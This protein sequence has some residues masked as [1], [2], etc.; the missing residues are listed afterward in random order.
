MRSVSRNFQSSLVFNG[1]SNRVKITNANLSTILPPNFLT[2]CAWVKTTGPDTT[3]NMMVFARDGGDAG[4]VWQLGINSSGVTFFKVFK[5]EAT[6]ATATGSRVITDGEWHFIMGTWDGTNIT[7]FVDGATDGSPTALSGTAINQTNNRDPY[8]GFWP[9]NSATEWYKGYMTGAALFNTPFTLAMHQNKYH[10]DVKYSQYLV[11]EHDSLRDVVDGSTSYKVHD[12]TNTVDADPFSADIK[13]L[14]VPDLDS[15]NQFV[16]NEVLVSAN[17]KGASIF[18]TASY[19]DSYL[20]TFNGNQYIVFIDTSLNVMVGKRATG[21]ASFTIVDTGFNITEDD[22]HNVAAIGIDPGGTIHLAWDHHGTTLEYARSNAPEDITAF[23][24]RAMVGTLEASVSY[25]RFFVANNILFFA[26]RDGGSIDGDE[27]LNK[28]T[29]ATTTWS[30]VQGPLVDGQTSNYGTYP[31]SYA[32]D[33]TGRI[34]HAFCWRVDDDPAILYEDFTYMYSDDN[35]ATWYNSAGVQYTLPV[36]PAQAGDIISGQISLFWPQNHIAIDHL[37]RP[38]IAYT[39]ASTRISRDNYFHAYLD[40][41]VWHHSQITDFSNTISSLQT[42]GNYN[43][44]RPN[45]VIKPSGRVYVFGR[46]VEEGEIRVYTSTDYEHWESF[47]LGNPPKG[48]GRMEMG[49]I[50]KTLWNESQILNLVADAG[51]ATNPDSLYVLESSLPERMN[52]REAAVGRTAT[53]ERMRVWDMGT[54]LSFNGTTSV[55]NLTQTAS[56]PLY[57]NTAFTIS[58]WIKPKAFSTNC[59][60]GEGSSASSIPV[61]EFDVVSGAGGGRFRYTVRNDSNV[62]QKNAALSAKAVVLNKWTH[63]TLV[64]NIGDVHLYMNGVEDPTTIANNWDYTRSTLTLNRSAFGALV[65]N[66]TSNY[67][68]GLLDNCRLYSRALSSAEV[69]ELYRTD[70]ISTTSLA[71]L[72]RFDEGSGTSAV[73]GSG[74]GNTGTITGGT[75]STDVFIKPRTAV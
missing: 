36:T 46:V 73:D 65:R 35:G 17:A 63:F 3:R 15:H 34:H 32:V 53:T 49:G 26:Y 27:V 33:S 16:V 69:G 28:Y 8:L 5:A 45:I 47:K 9:G 19:T 43:F 7:I 12:V 70:L 75:Y 56:L 4:H 48:W 52:G 21:A 44:C 14:Q 55:V 74:L 62:F 42:F 59:I 39:K 60:W 68:N 18:N 40:D 64:D 50:D 58:G 25:P 23:T 10:N 6:S 2:V 22:D 29:V 41:G 57:N 11:W 51:F 1:T 72:Y 30:R 20:T 61:Y 13:S 37:N 54:S 24:R 66:T 38:H 71:G 31:D 67:F